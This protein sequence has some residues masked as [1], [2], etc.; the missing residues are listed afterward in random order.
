MMMPPELPKKLRRG[1]F[2]PMHQE[3]R[4]RIHQIPNDKS[5]QKCKAVLAQ[6]E[7]K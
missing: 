4:G 5:R 6:E 2:H 1:I 7:I 3:V